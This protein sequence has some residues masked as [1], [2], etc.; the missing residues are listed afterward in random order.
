MAFTSKNDRVEDKKIGDKFMAENNP[1]VPDVKLFFSFIGNIRFLAL[2]SIASLY[3]IS[4]KRLP[5]VE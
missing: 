5:S 1:L 2:I 3:T 4:L